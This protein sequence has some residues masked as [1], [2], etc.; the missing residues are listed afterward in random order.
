MTV[1]PDNIRRIMAQ[2]GFIQKAVAS[3][4][5]FSQQ[6]F[7]DML[8]GRKMIRAEYIPAIADALG[9]KINELYGGEA[10]KSDDR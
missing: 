10:D 4:S 5:G 1:V 3:R 6:Q 2:K 9:V 7:S 8:N